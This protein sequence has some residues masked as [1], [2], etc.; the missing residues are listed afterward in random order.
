MEDYTPTP[1]QLGVAWSLAWHYGHEWAQAMAS[2]FADPAYGE[3][4]DLYS[5]SAIAETTR[6]SRVSYALPG[7]ESPEAVDHHGGTATLEHTTGTGRLR[8][9]VWTDGSVRFTV[10]RPAGAVPGAFHRPEDDQGYWVFEAV[11]GPASPQGPPLN[12]SWGEYPQRKVW[13]RS[14]EGAYSR[15]WYA[16]ADAIR[17]VHDWDNGKARE[18]AREW[19]KQQEDMAEYIRRS[20][21]EWR[22]A[23]E[24]PEAGTSAPPEA[25]GTTTM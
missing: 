5:L 22:R 25:A 7:I 10:Y 14:R 13:V 12:G 21:E 16:L 17:A 4:D 19:I 18:R 24:S 9:A 15:H 1:E 6:A 20:N 11:L 3:S 2:V 23:H 8:W